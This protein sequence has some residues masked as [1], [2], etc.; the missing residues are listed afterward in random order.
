MPMLKH[1]HTLHKRTDFTMIRSPIH[2]YPQCC[3]EVSG[4]NTAIKFGLVDSTAWK[5]HP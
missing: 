5:K 4:A 1:R 2:V 3:A